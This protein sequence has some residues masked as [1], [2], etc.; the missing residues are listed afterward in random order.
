V[1]SS[2]LM[3]DL[4]LDIKSQLLSV[5]GVNTMISDESLLLR[6]TSCHDF[7]FLKQDSKSS[8]C[9]EFW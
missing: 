3:I 7:I 9:P 2:F 5:F 6:K 1:L 4:V 8:S